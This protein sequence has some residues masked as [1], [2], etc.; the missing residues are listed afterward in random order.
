MEHVADP[1]RGFEEIRRIL[2][3]GGHHICTIPVNWQREL[4]VA[5]AVIEHGVIRHIM[6]PDYHGD[7]T[8][9]DG[10]LAFT[11]FGQDIVGRWC[12]I[13]GPSTMHAANGDVA[14]ELAFGV[15]NSWVFISRKEIGHEPPR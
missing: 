4:T 3:P 12:A 7:P 8:R 15:Y 10:V 13:T 9:P 14:A 6:T 1:R 2:R 11:E 5:R